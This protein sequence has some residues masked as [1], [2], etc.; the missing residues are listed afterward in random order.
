MGTLGQSGFK[1]EFLACFKKHARPSFFRVKASLIG[2]DW[3]RCRHQP[4]VQLHM[5]NLCVCLCRCPPSTLS[6]L[7]CTYADWYST[8]LDR[9]KLKQ[10]EKCVCGGGADIGKLWQ[11]PASSRILIFLLSHFCVCV[12]VVFKF[13]SSSPCKLWIVVS[14]CFPQPHPAVFSVCGCILYIN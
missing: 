1:R 5:Y 7:C 9:N 13:C 10:W 3:T 11:N 12:C 6:Q 2:F 4:T 8:A 14:V